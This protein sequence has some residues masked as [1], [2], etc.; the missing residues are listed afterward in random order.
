M[1]HIVCSTPRDNRE[2]TFARVRFCISFN[3]VELFPLLGID[4]TLL[5]HYRLA[6]I[7]PLRNPIPDLVEIPTRVWPIRVDVVVLNS[8]EVHRRYRSKVTGTQNDLPKVVDAV[9]YVLDAVDG[10]V[11]RI[12][13]WPKALAD[14]VLGS[15]FVSQMLQGLYW[16]SGGGRGGVARDVSLSPTRQW[17]VCM[18]SRLLMH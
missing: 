4:R 10:I 9:V 12:N 6:A 5:R 11:G 8:H 2:K 17:I 16:A 15:R 7:E 18:T 13:I 1:E 14:V 3:T